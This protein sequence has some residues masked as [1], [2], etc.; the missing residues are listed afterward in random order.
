MILTNLSSSYI[1]GSLITLAVSKR[2]VISA[3]NE[4]KQDDVSRSPRQAVHQSGVMA[5]IL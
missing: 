5:K 4:H 3:T 2:C 1:V